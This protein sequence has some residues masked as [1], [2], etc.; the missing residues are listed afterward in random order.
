MF[1]FSDPWNPFW[2]FRFN[3]IDPEPITVLVIPEDIMLKMSVFVFVS[4]CL[5]DCLFVLNVPT[6]AKVIYRRGHSLNFHLT[7]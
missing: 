1:L 7:D 2:G 5:F 4:F 3:K 6:T